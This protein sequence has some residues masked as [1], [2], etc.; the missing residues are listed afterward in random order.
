MKISIA[1]TPFWNLPLEKTL[2]RIADVGYKAV[3]I[4]AFRP[5]GFPYDFDQTSRRKLKQFLASR[6]LEVAALAQG[7]FWGNAEPP[8]LN[9]ASFLAKEQKE[10]LEYSKACLEFAAALEARIL[11]FQPGRIVEGDIG[12][13]PNQ[14]EEAWRSVR[15]KL[16]ELGDVAH[17]LD[18]LIA[19]EAGPS[20][21]SL[22][23]TPIEELKM[24]S[25]VDS[26]NVRG[27]LNIGRLNL[28]RSD[29][30]IESYIAKTKDVIVH[31]R[32]S[33]NDGKTESR[34]PVGMGSVDWPRT[35][36]ALKA[37]GYN[38]Y[39]SVDLS[40]VVHGTRDSFRES[41]CLTARENLERT[42]LDIEAR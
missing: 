37:T 30:S 29:A 19:V 21:A 33:D 1:T 17:G 28:L 5:H 35:L 40:G 18:L 36:R 16:H 11:L 12:K 22:V 38:G 15:G 2:E 23:P 41:Y 14:R 27:S 7:A 9:A 8:N 4:V 13:N 3:E 39:L 6:G 32:V 26:R 34:L 42:L 24:I 31:V 25:E 10:A 20:A